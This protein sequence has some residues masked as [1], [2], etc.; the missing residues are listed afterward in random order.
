MQQGLIPGQEYTNLQL[1]PETE[2]RSGNRKVRASAYEIG[3]IA[4]AIAAPL[5]APVHSRDAVPLVLVKLL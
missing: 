3:P 4:Y 2:N 5:P 1:P